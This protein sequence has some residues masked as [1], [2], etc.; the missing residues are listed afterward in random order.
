[1]VVY[2]PLTDVAYISMP[3]LPEGGLKFDSFVDLPTGTKLAQ[4]LLAPTVHKHVLLLITS[5]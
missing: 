2:A 3:L 4:L 1:M 5:L